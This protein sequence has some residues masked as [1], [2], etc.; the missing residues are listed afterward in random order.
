MKHKNWFIRA[1]II[2]IA[3]W[4]LV[5]T[6]ILAEEHR[7]MMDD[8]SDRKQML[9]GMGMMNMM[10]NG[11][12]GMMGQGGMMN[13]MQGG[14]MGM[15]GQGSMMQGCDMGMM[16]GSG[17]TN[18]LNLNDAQRKKIRNIR[19]AA[20]KEHFVLLTTTLDVQED[21]SDLLRE[22]TPDPAAVGMAFRRWA[23]T[24]QKVIEARVETRNK[25]RAVLN[26]EQREQMNNM[27]GRRGMMMQ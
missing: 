3:T 18:R 27:M 26:K 20:R 19:R 10:Q 2:S 24:K 22:D 13:M 17:M 12:M 14:G 25:I 8:S 23:D 1:I 15:M 16:M 21:F 4:G 7:M 11:G 5:T 9:G 6:G